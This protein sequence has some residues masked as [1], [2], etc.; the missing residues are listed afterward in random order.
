M[1]WWAG[2]RR[3]TEGGVQ[4][5]A[6]HDAEPWGGPRQQARLG[7]FTLIE[8]LVVIAIIAVLISLLLPALGQA[9]RAARRTQCNTQLQQMG[10]G[11]ASYA[12]DNRDYIWNYSWR[13]KDA[14]RSQY[15]DL[16]TVTTDMDAQRSQYVDTFRRLTDRPM[17]R[18]TTLLPQIL[19]GHLVLFDYLASRLPEPIYTC[20]SD[21]VRLTWARDIDGYI[22]GSAAP[23]PSSVGIP[24]PAGNRNIRWA[25]SSSYEVT[26]SAFDGLQTSA[27]SGEVTY[28]LRNLPSNHFIFSATTIWKLRQQRLTSV[29]YPSHKVF[30]HEGHSRHGRKET[31]YASAAAKS[32]LLFF[33][34]SSAYKGTDQA[35]PGWDPWAPASGSG[36]RYTYAPDAWEAPQSTPG[37]QVY[38]YYRYTRGGLRGID[39]GGRE[40]SAR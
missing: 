38:G 37:E 11:T 3:P 26:I 25:Y 18:D 10:V 20:P 6:F 33:D 21:R 29:A 31:Y 28:R 39:L 7:G 1:L 23:Y 8:L 17:D 24:I 4:R 2:V 32:N 19:Y 34:G 14:L 27:G 12:I 35:N 5:V 30:L 13:I 40:I 16:R 15:P 9:R 36:F 22:N